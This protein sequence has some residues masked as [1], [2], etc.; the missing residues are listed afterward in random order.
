MRTS[1]LKLCPIHDDTFLDLGLKYGGPSPLRIPSYLSKKVKISTQ[2]E[3]RQWHVE[4][5]ART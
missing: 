3:V 5:G 1:Q 2:L 4:V